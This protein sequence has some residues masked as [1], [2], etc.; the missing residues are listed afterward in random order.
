MKKSLI[1]LLLLLAVFN[2][3]TFAQDEDDEIIKDNL[4]VILYGGLG[5]PSGDLSDWG[6]DSLAVGN[7]VDVGFDVG[8][9]IKYNIVA[10]INF[11]YTNFAIDNP[12]SV[13]VGNLTHRLYSPSLYLKYYLPTDGDFIPYLKGTIGLD[14]A[15]FTTSVD[16][17][18]GS[19]FRQLS[20][21]PALSYSIGLGAFYYTFDFG[22]LYLEGNYHMSQTEDAKH[23][24]N[25]GG[26]FGSNIAKI[27]LKLGVRILFS[28]EE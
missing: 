4:E 15:K 6:G 1:Y 2:F 24:Y 21:D 11:N 28:P 26:V 13:D 9:F 16:N 5:L 12:E 18:F 25:D 23:T 3:S 7:G 8:Y 19:R 17:P 20:Y 27:D 14:Y 10:G 22:G